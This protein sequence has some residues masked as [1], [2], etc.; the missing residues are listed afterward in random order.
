MHATRGMILAYCLFEGTN[1]QI[2]LS[3]H[4][5]RKRFQKKKKKVKEEF[6]FEL[7]FLFCSSI[8]SFCVPFLFPYWTSGWAQASRG[9]ARKCHH[10]V[11][12]GR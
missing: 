12:R 2:I 8:R 11:G 3:K 7:K 4:L 9:R 5:Q 1:K 6:V 10:V